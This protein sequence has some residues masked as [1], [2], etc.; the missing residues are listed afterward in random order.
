M[1]ENGT[2]SWKSYYEK[3]GARPPRETLL[4]ALDRFENDLSATDRRFAIDLGCGNGRDTIEL[5]RRSWQVLAIDAEAAAISGLT[6]RQ[7]LPPDST[8]ETL[9]C[10]FEDMSLPNADLVNSSFALPLVDPPKF[11]NLWDNIL[12]CVRSG[13]RIA[14]QL[15][16]DRDSWVGRPGI[17]FF[18]KSGIDALLEPLDV[19]FFREEEDDS[20]TPRNHQK[21]W[22]IFHIV[23]KRP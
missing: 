3:T 5:L 7:D 20:V 18:T 6:S 22:H 23:A 11:P 1:S 15:Y 4:F 21:H 10:P 13:G 9:I 17:T 12:D 16:G 8:L 19:E 2:E 14:C